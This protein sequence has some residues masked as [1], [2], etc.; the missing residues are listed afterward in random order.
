MST[1]RP[2]KIGLPPSERGGPAGPV[3]LAW[4]NDGTRVVAEGNSFDGARE[5]ALAKGETNPIIEQEPIK[6]RWA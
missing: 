1:T 2:R 3:F 4:S 6:A 5:A